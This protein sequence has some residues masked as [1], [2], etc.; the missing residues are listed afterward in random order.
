MP[1]IELSRRVSCNFKKKIYPIAKDIFYY[2]KF[3]VY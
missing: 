3:S 1:R 2:N